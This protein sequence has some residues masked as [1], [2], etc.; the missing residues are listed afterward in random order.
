MNT[1]AINQANSADLRGSWDALLRAA[2]RARELASQTGTELV[3]TRNGIIEHVKPLPSDMA[4]QEPS[5][6]YGD[7]S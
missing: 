7:N 4:V 1:K 6:R 3:I 2:R 5:P